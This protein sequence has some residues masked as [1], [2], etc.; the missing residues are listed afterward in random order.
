MIFMSC[1]FYNLSR[2]CC[3]FHCHR[4][5]GRSECNASSQLQPNRDHFIFI[6]FRILRHDNWTEK[7]SFIFYIESNF[8]LRIQIPCEPINQL[9]NNK[10][11]PIFVNLIGSPSLLCI[12]SINLCIFQL[13]FS[14]LAVGIMEIYSLLLIV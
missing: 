9:R 11:L 3:H 8:Q 13:R 14:L 7:T 4:L 6:P 1:K 12:Y 10:S 2:P 5:Y